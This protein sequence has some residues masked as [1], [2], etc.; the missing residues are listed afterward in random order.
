ML[1]ASHFPRRTWPSNSLQTFPLALH[2]RFN[3][4]LVTTFLFTCALGHVDPDS[5]LPRCINRLF[6]F[7]F[8][9]FVYSYI[10]ILDLKGA[11]RPSTTLNPRNTNPILPPRL[12][13]LPS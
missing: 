8:F 1:A 5:C 12:P 2:S 9:L 3:D 4:H 11:I 6:F 7:H 13:T 10:S